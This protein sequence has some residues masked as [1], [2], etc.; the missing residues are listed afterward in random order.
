MTDKEKHK[1]KKLLQNIDLDTPSINF[2]DKV[3]E[4]VNIIPDDMI[5]RDE[6][7]SSLLKKN[8]LEI[9]SSD[10]SIKIMTK[11]NT[12]SVTDYKPIISKKGWNIIFLLF[13]SF[14]IYALLFNPTTTQNNS[15]TSKF[16]TF[17]NDLITNFGNSLSQNIQVPSILIVSILCLSVLLLL[18]T[19]L[20]TKKLF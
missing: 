15:Y 7:L 16:L 20:R 18:D 11:V 19:L 4:K 14:V 13:T 17:F 2:T 3:M 10:F 8:S 9:P 12:Y 5:L 1:T 6:V